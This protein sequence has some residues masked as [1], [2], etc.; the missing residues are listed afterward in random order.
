MFE[1]IKN[2]LNKIIN[3]FNDTARDYPKDKTVIELFEE[4][5]KKYSDKIALV[6]EGKHLTYSDLNN[7]AN[8]LANELVKRGIKTGDSVGIIVDK[9]FEL[10]ISILAVL[11][12]GAYYLPI[13]I[14]YAHDRKKYM[15]E[16]NN[17]KVVIQ[18]VYESFTNTESILLNSID[19]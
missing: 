9:S 1:Q 11:K 5:A 7:R 12:I 17:T 4:T 18:Q 6:F 19:R 10:L 13:E 8:I 16:D 15:L 3:I 14:N 2:D